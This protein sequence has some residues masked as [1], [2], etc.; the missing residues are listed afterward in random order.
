MP[1]SGPTKR[2]PPAS[3]ASARRAEPT[4]GST[5]AR[6]TVPRGE[7]APG[8]GQREGAGDHVVGRQLVRDVDERRRRG[9]TVR[10]A[11]FIAPT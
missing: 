8:G 10:I 11:P 5:T 3:S 1:L 6:K 2:W 4:P 7:G 9:Q